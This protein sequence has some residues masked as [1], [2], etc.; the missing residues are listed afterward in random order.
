MI[1]GS[2][3]YTPNG[4]S[5]IDIFDTAGIIVNVMKPRIDEEG[6][7]ILQFVEDPKTKAKLAGM[8]AR[9][10]GL[11]SKYYEKLD[12]ARLE[13]EKGFKIFA[14]HSGITEFKPAF[15]ER[16]GDCS[17]LLLSKGVR[18]LRGRTHP[19]ERRTSVEW[20]SEDCFPGPSVHW[21]RQGHRGDCEGSK[22]WILSRR[23]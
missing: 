13:R 19:R 3:D 20:L 7:L 5:I 21:I 22:A 12:K 2:H 8:S 15:L 16:H 1:Y 4:I 9:R 6:V 18:L 11:E 17:N 10:I 14:F 23:V